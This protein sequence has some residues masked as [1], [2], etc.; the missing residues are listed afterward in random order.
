MNIRECVR[1]VN[2]YLRVEENKAKLVEHIIKNKPSIKMVAPKPQIKKTEL[3]K[4]KVIN[5]K[6]KRR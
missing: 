4:A 1:C 2:D 5:D 3:K 6:E